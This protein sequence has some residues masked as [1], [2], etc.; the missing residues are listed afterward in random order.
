MSERSEIERIEAKIREGDE[1]IRGLRYL[2]CECGHR[3]W[4]HMSDGR[5][6]ISWLTPDGEGAKAQCG[7]AEFVA[8]D[9]G[10]LNKIC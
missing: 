4:I 2:E 7:C 6:C 10:M 8:A 9:P 5:G 3:A 1:A